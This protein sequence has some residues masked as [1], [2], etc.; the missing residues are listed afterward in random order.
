MAGL[1]KM[2]ILTQNK[3]ENFSLPTKSNTHLTHEH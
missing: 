2:E 3:M 1:V